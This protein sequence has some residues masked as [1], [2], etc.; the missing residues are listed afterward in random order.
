MGEDLR[1]SEGDSRRGLVGGEGEGEGFLSYRA[2]TPL[3]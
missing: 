1:E 3:L 2:A